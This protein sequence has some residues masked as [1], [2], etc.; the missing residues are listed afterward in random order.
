MNVQRPE[1]L[2]SLQ[3]GGRG[4]SEQGLRGAQAPSALTVA[5]IGGQSLPP[6]L[7][8]CTIPG[9]SILSPFSGQAPHLEWHSHLPSRS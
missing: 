3:W 2:R 1:S 7:P 9:P 8:R 5:G 4:G 6:G